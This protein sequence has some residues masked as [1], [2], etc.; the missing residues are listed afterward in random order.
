MAKTIIIYNDIIEINQ[1]LTEHGLSFKLHMRDAC[2]SQSF[3]VE[4]MSNCSTEGRYEEMQKTIKDYFARKNI[5]IQ[6]LSN[7]LEFMITES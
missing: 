7:P 6:F 1:I 3:W 2:G 5:E 4:P